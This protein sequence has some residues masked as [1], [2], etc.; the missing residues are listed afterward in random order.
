MRLLGRNLLRMARWELTLSGRPGGGQAAAAVVSAAPIANQ[1]A[2]GRLAFAPDVRSFFGHEPEL[3]LPE[4]TRRVRLHFEN[5]YAGAVELVMEPDSIRGEAR[6]RVNGGRPR[7]PDDFRPT[8]AHVP[9]CIGVDVT[10]DLVPGANRVTVEVVTNRLDGGLLNPLYLAGDFGVSLEP[11][12]LRAPTA[13]GLFEDYDA[14]FAPFYSGTVE[15]GM[16]A[17]LRGVPRGGNVLLELA[18]PRHFEEAC[19]VSLNGHPFRPAPWSPYR[20]VVPAA[21][22]SNGANRRPRAR[23]HHAGPRLRRHPLRRGR[24]PLRSRLKAPL[25]VRPRT[26]GYRLRLRASSCSHAFSAPATSP[27]RVS[28]ARAFFFINSS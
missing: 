17:T 13:G 18:L 27:K 14:N 10:A 21:E 5:S 22:I 15:Y 11:L 28:L 7:V 4:L 1:I 12:A 3:L 26:A 9:G 19:E 25:P 6:V 20:I 24:S 23:A 8:D 16:E 2:E